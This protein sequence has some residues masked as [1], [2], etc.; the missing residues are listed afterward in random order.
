[1]IEGKALIVAVMMLTAAPIAATDGGQAFLGEISSDIGEIF[2]TNEEK[3]KDFEGK[4][5]LLTDENIEV[6]CL[7]LEQWKEEF[8]TEG[9]QIV[10][11]ENNAARNSDDKE[12]DEKKEDYSD[13]EDWADKETVVKEDD[14][15]T[16]EEWTLKFESDE[17]EPC[18]TLEDLEK[19]MRDGKEDWNKDWHN[20]GERDWD[21]EWFEEL[22]V[23]AKLCN[24]GDEEACEELLAVRE[25]LAEDREEEERD[26]EDDGARGGE[27]ESDEEED[28]GEHSHADDK[29]DDHSHDDDEA[30]DHNHVTDRYDENWEEIRA[31]MQ[32]LAQA[33]E[34]GDEEACV[35]LREM[36][37]EMMDDRKEKD[38]DQGWDK[39]WDREEKDWDDDACLTMEEWKKIFGD[40][41]DDRKDDRKGD[42]DRK[43]RGPHRD[44]FV[45]EIIED[46][47]I[48]CNE[49]DE[50]ACE[51]LEAMLAEL[52]EK[53]GSCDKERDN[54]E[55]DEDDERNDDESD[56]EEQDQDDSEDDDPENAQ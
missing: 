14:C 31:V 9:E 25:E 44:V 21:E 38:W 2:D 8:V 37:A 33:C 1:M 10:R 20:E 42:D 55:H 49:D 29:A 41:K 35:D 51:E 7:T 27:D 13:K 43:K 4:E 5:L 30:D 48:A 46:L 45:R 24:E 18:F 6:D 11:E 3:N 23:L 15:L 34:D 26:D 39:G 36:I 12:T 28:D 56:E 47:E 22:E 52:E 50:E 53:E 17:K 40:D 54:D 32:E 16:A 19:K